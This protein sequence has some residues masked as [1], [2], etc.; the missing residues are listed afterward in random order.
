L[1][2]GHVHPVHALPGLEQPPRRSRLHP[3]TNTLGV[4]LG[5]GTD[6]GDRIG[7]ALDQ[8]D[9]GCSG[10]VKNSLTGDYIRATAAANRIGF[11]TLS[12]ELSIGRDNHDR[13]TGLSA[14][15]PL[16]P[17]WFR[18]QA[19]VHLATEAGAAVHPR[20]RGRGRCIYAARR[21]GET[22]VA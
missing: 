4:Q 12:D 13:Y 19:V 6:E 2:A 15:A 10:Y 9:F 7:A 11:L 3:E 17:R 5:H 1:P 8:S 16:P 21:P 20:R 18:D 22:I 14:S